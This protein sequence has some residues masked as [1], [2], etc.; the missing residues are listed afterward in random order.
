MSFHDD[1][2]DNKEAYAII[3]LREDQY[4]SHDNL[5]T[6][7]IYEMQYSKLIEIQNCEELL[8]ELLQCYYMKNQLNKKCQ[9]LYEERVNDLIKCKM[10]ISNFSLEGMKKNIINFEL[11][12]DNDKG[13]NYDYY[14]K[15]EGDTLILEDLFKL[16]KDFNL[17]EEIEID[18]INFQEEPIIENKEKENFIIVDKRDCVEYELSKKDNNYIVCNKYE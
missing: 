10:M 11:D 15:E 5:N 17:K 7:D 3:D 2:N 16:S 4:D 1:T 9:K 6:Y 8:D 12:S 14:F 18:D 13:N